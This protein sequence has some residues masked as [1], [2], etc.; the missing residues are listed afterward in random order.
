[1]VNTFE[2]LFLK[3]YKIQWLCHF[4]ASSAPQ[5]PNDSFILH[6]N[7]FAPNSIIFLGNIAIFKQNDQC[8]DADLYFWNTCTG[9]DHT[10]QT[11]FVFWL[12]R[13]NPRGEQDGPLNEFNFTFS[14]TGKQREEGEKQDREN[15]RERWAT[16]CAVTWSQWWG[17]RYDLSD[18]PTIMQPLDRCRQSD[19]ICSYYWSRHCDVCKVSHALS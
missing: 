16:D 14:L 17:H 5:F 4:K 18:W 12:S 1:M 19:T 2:K 8:F 15:E 13:I 7:N 10:A 9:T 11:V 6:T 3:Y